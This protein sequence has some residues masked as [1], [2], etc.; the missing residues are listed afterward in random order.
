MHLRLVPDVPPPAPPTNARW[1]RAVLVAAA[2]Y[3][4]AWAVFIIVEPA[5]L[6]RSLGALPPHYP[7]LWQGVGMLVAASGVGYALAALDPL[8]HW[9]ITFV[10]LLGKVL[11]PVTF[12]IAAAR[13]ELPWPVGVTFVAAAMVWWVP[14]ALILA[15]AW[16]AHHH[17]PTA[18]SAERLPSRKRA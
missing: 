5:G 4:V 8:A 15:A 17:L 14:F 9:P 7:G 3:N 2:A 10:G 1:M 6:F 11:G 13:G 18:A 16:R 12:A